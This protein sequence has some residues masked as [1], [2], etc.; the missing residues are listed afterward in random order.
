MEP[1]SITEVPDG[2]QTLT[3]NSFWNPNMHAW[4][5][6]E[7]RTHTKRGLM[8]LPLLHTPYIWDHWSAPLSKCLLRV[9]G[10]VR[11]PITTLDCILL[12]ENYTYT[13]CHWLIE[14]EFYNVSYNPRIIQYLL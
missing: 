14:F 12:K 6:P 3:L 2:P 13:V 10:P 9:L 11:R 4:V 1:C 5:K 7:L 8:F